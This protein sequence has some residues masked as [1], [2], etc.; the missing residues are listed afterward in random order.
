MK[1]TCWI[2]FGAMISTSLLAQQAPTAAAPGT[3][4]TPAP[5]GIATNVPAATAATNAPAAKAPSKKTATPK[6][7]APAV[8]RKD[9]AAELRTVPLVPGPAT[10][11]ANNVNVRGQAKLKSEI[12]S[13]LKK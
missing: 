7:K 2:L 6:K 13:R 5:A 10:V 3:I 8:K 1:K 4:E 11:E 12:V 9:P